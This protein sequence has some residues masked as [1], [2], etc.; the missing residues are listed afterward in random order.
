[1]IGLE[2]CSTAH[3]WGRILQGLGHQVRL[4]PPAYAKAYVRRNKTD[5]PDAK[6]I[7]EAVS[8]PAMR[9]VPLKSPADQAMAA[10]PR[11][12]ERLIAQRKMLI[13]TLRGHMA[14]FG[15]VAAAGP[16]HVTELVA[17][18]AAPGSG[19]EALRQALLALAPRSPSSAKSSCVASPSIA[20]I[21]P[22]AAAIST[23]RVS[24]RSADLSTS[25]AG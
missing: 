10:V 15:I 20:A 2:A 17:E 24:L 12:R 14:E 5:P 6:A 4:I 11:V 22:R 18:L 16:Q 19:P 3:H 1:V 21:A 23:T 25:R 7:C 13:N 8:R 9:F